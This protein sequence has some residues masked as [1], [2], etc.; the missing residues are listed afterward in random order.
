M[1]TAV[2]AA[3]TASATWCS[4]GC[5]GGWRRASSLR[6][7][8]AVVTRSK[9]MAMMTIARPPLKA[10]PMSRWFSASSTTRP[11]PGA[12]ISAARVTIDRAAMMVWLIPMTTVRLATGRVTLS[13]ICGRVVP[14]DSAASIVSRGTCRMPWAVIRMTGGAA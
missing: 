14:S 6:T 9:T 4:R 13:S 1:Q 8:A 10:V 5:R 3:P 12:S 7:L 2:T 11:S